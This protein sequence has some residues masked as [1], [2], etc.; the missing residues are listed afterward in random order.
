MSLQYSKDDIERVNNGASYNR[1][2]LNDEDD[3]LLPKPAHGSQV[4]PVQPSNKYAM[5]I[6]LMVLTVFLQSIGFTVMMPSMFDYLKYI[7]PSFGQ[8]NGWIIACYSAGQFIASPLFGWWSNRRPTRE[9]LVISIV[10]SMIGNILYAVCYLF[11]SKAVFIMAVARFIVGFGAGNVSVCRAFASE[12]SDISNK[13]T[14]MGK[15]SGAQGVGFVLGPGIGFLM[16]Y[17][18][19]QKGQF[20]FNQYTAP[21]YLSV[22]T[23]AFNILILLIKFDPPREDKKS[24]GEETKPLLGGDVE[25]DG[26]SVGTPIKKAHNE[27]LPIFVSIYLFAVVIS[28]FAVFETILTEMTAKDY[29]WQVKANGF[30]LGGTGILSVAVFI[31]IAMPFIKK[32]DDRK[33]AL[34]GFLSLFIALLLLANYGAPFHWENSLPKW[35]FFL[36]SVFVSIGYPIAS[37]LIYAIFSKVLNPKL[38]GTKMG[39]LTAGGSLARMLGPIW[40]QSIWNYKADTSPTLGGEVLFFTTAGIALSGFVVLLAFYRK[41]SPH[42]DYVV[43]ILQQK[44]PTSTPTTPTTTATETSH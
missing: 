42:P 27:T 18:H 21:A 35:Q 19:A 28:I 31:I 39:W 32:I 20:L 43:P 1:Y 5:Y 23:A 26:A 2:T 4:H 38:Q 34:F 29:N 17:L 10:I 37:S 40:A 36:G 11:G 13:T 3:D 33:T 15:M 22:V 24:A 8:Y 30:I 12:K 6:N 16:A 14:T 25:E 9:P 44:P 7:D 41:L